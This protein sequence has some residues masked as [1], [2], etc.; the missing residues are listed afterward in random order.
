MHKICIPD[1]YLLGQTGPLSGLS[2]PS[3]NRAPTR[4]RSGK[5]AA[6]CGQGRAEQVVL[7]RA[8]DA[9]VM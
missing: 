6:C 5:T 3:D 4:L 7:T 1:D 8:I 9:Y 2:V